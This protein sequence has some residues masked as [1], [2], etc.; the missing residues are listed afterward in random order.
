MADPGSREAGEAH[1]AL[2]GM[3]GGDGGLVCGGVRAESEDTGARRATECEMLE[4]KQNCPSVF[5][6]LRWWVR[7]SPDFYRGRKSG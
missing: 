7:N 1:Q 2:K 3:G 5:P 4:V 6:Q